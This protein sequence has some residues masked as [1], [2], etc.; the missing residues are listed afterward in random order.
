MKIDD[1]ELVFQ[2]WVPK[3]RVLGDDGEIIPIPSYHLELH[4]C[5]KCGAVT[6]Q[7]GITAHIG[8]HSTIE[9][10]DDHPSGRDR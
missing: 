4:Q 8:W 1:F 7:T 5:P 3:T 9:G 2:A 10:H 6:S